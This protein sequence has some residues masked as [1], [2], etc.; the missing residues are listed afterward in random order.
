MIAIARYTVLGC[1]MVTLG[2]YGGSGGSLEEAQRQFELHNYHAALEQLDEFLDSAEAGDDVGE[3]SALRARCLLKLGRRDEGVAAMEKLFEE[4]PEFAARPE[5]HMAIGESRGRRQIADAPAIKHLEIAFNLYRKAGQSEQAAEAAFQLGEAFVHFHEW[6][7]LEAPDVDVPDDWQ[8]RRKLQQR[9]AIQWLDRALELTD[10]PAMAAQATFRKGRVL[11]RELRIDPEDLDRALETYKELLS[12]WPDATEAPSALFDIAQI[13]QQRDQDY[14]A[15]AQRYRELI[16]RFPRSRS[17][18]RA[19]RLLEQIVEPIVNVGVEGPA[20]PGERAN[21]QVSLRNV[22]RVAFKAYRVDLFDLVRDV[23][24]PGRLSDWSPSGSPAETWSIDVPDKGKHEYF[25]THDDTLDPVTTPMLEPGAYVILASAEGLHGGSAKGTAL[26][27]VSRLATVTK[28]GKDGGLVWA[29][30]A[31][32]GEPINGADVLV[33]QRIGHDR[34]DY[35]EGTTNDAGLFYADRARDKRHGGHSLAVY[36]RDAESYAVCDTAYYWYWWG[37]PEGY[38]AYTFTERPV[39]RPDQP[40]RFKHIVRRYIGG[41]YQNVPNKRVQMTVRDP[42][43]ETVEERTLTTND[44]GTVAG[45]LRLPSQAA[46]G[47]YRI[48]LQIAGQYVDSG[49]G[50]RFRVEEYRKP[51]FEVTVKSAQTRYGLFEPV[52][53]RI[54]AKYYFGSPVADAELKYTVHRAPIR[55][56][57][58]YPVPYPWYF[59]QLAMMWPGGGAHEA[60][61]GRWIWRPE[62]KE[63]VDRGELRTDTQGVAIVRIPPEKPLPDSMKEHGFRYIVEAEVIDSSRRTVTGSGSVNITPA[64][65]TIKVTPQRQLYQPGDNVQIDIQARGP[66]GDPVEF[67][68][69]LQVHRTEVREVQKP[70][71]TK[72]QVSEPDAVVARGKVESDSQGNARYRWVADEDGRFHVSVTADDTDGAV[73][74]TCDVWVARPGGRFEHHAY[75]DVELVPDKFVYEIG[76]TARVLINSRRDQADVLVTL[77]ADDLLEHRIVRLT[78]GGAILEIPIDATHTPNFYM[79]ATLVRDN[80][81]FEDKRAIVVPPTRQ[82]LTVDIVSPETTFGPRDEAPITLTTNDSAGRPVSAELAVMMVDA[83][84]YYIQPEL[85][86]AIQEHFYG[87]IRPHMVRT[88][89]S[90]DVTSGDVVYTLGGE[91]MRQ[92]KGIALEQAAPAAAVPARAAMADSAAPEEPEFAVAEIRREFPDS[93]FWAGQVAT[94]SDGK[95]DID[96]QFPDTLTT[97]KMIAIAVDEDTRVGEDSQEFITRKNVIARLQTPRFLVEGD[98]CAI[99]VIARNDLPQEKLARVSLEASGPVTIGDARVDGAEVDYVKPDTVE[100]QVPPGSEAVVDFTVVAI[101]PGSAT[102][103]GTVATDVEADAMELELP[104][105][106][107]GAPKLVAQ[108]GVIRAGDDVTSALIAFTLPQEMNTET[109]VL[110]VHV[111][112][113]IA[114][115]MLDAIPY[116]LDYPYGCTEQTMSRFLPAVITRKTLDKLGVQLEELADRIPEETARDE[117]RRR[118]RQRNPVFRR[119][120]LEDIVSAGL[121]RLA[122]LQSPDGGWGWWRSASSDPYMTAYVVY[123]LAEA[124]RSGVDVDDTMLNRGVNVLQSFIADPVRLER[125]Y[126]R[127]ST[128]NLR[129]W[130]LYALTTADALDRSDPRTR[131][132]VD[133][134]YAGRDD[135]T[136]YGRAMLALVLHAGGDERADVVIDNLENT[137]RIDEETQT[138]SWGRAT[139]YWRWYDNGL[140]ATSMVL[141]ALLTVRP[142]HPH[143]DGAVNWLVRNRKGARW[144][145]TKDT[146]FAVYAMSEYLAHSGELDADMTVTVTLDD[147]VTRSFRITPENVLT[148]DAKLIFAPHHASPGEHEVRIEKD[149][150]GSIYHAT[151]VDY[152]TKE[153]PI[154]AAGHEV[155]ANRTFEKLTPKEVEMTRKVWHAEKRKYVD[156]TYQAISY[157]RKPIEPGDV[158]DAGDLIEV[159]LEIEARNDFEYI[160]VEDPKPAGCEPVSLRSGPQYGDSLYA[161]SELRDKHVAFFANYLR[162]GTHKLSYRLRCETPGRFAVL[163]TQVEA[164]YSPYVRANAASNRLEIEP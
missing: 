112:P 48:Q 101:E 41:A 67:S 84:L 6:E 127:T 128:I 42:R 13:H 143:V 88:Q 154:E 144:H 104:V 72:E 70:D 74:G 87:R 140:E 93:V 43:G 90:F 29:V 105:L 145:S 95:A 58:P 142:D 44:N 94:G 121:A 116:L 153:D 69:K 96:V 106:T 78:G 122:E 118:W 149:G 117:A 30:D 81:V 120:V 1:L 37:Y 163:P 82:F 46:L 130:I 60:P 35:T 126:H 59:D 49:A 15:A 129:A 32:T 53:V 159:T 114:G 26:L 99:T 134:V 147:S 64:P 158:L 162:Q 65:F 115:V 19:R 55:P 152:F 63:L 141:R 119:A 108:S 3:A 11:Y 34:Y 61:W 27:V 146:A 85:R 135:L 102:F 156:E 4:R 2:L 86:Q 16:E 132:V 110:E 17:A 71:G 157:D 97:W 111:N 28:S 45:E 155:V 124:K 91:G 52:E 21:L 138:A 18:A 22:G 150:K 57:F 33:Q 73:E 40:I 92:A 133:D 54:E 62:S 50:S 161:H 148:F 80:K 107:Y 89:T 14:A 20:M 25:R 36:V 5:L 160:V 66:N 47:M 103:T 76:E 23:G 77:E 39:Y 8:E 139:G 7:N 9:F 151:Y 100:V 79:T 131:G 75:R 56:V 31:L 24:H 68:G 113:T 125:S 123:G 83:S 12:R 10:D 136:D 38:R 98:R 51:E 137:V 109:P 164:M